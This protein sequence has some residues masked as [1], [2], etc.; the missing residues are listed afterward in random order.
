MYHFD[1]QVAVECGGTQSGGSCTGAAMIRLKYSSW[2][3]N[4]SIRPLMDSNR[5]EASRLQSTFQDTSAESLCVAT[6][7]LDQCVDHIRQSA[8]QHVLDTGAALFYILV[9]MVN[10][11]TSLYLP[12]KQLLSTCIE[13]LGEP[14]NQCG[15]DPVWNWI[16]FGT[17]PGGGSKLRGKGGVFAGIHWGRSRRQVALGLVSVSVK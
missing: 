4:A 13:G 12:A 6:V 7:L 3:L 8:Q 9:E 11:E 1:R 15:P 2:K 14:F 16:A 10:E 17:E 5:L